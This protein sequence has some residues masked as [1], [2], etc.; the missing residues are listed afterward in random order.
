MIFYRLRRFLIS[1]PLLFFRDG[2]E[3]T[4]EEKNYD[5]LI[6]KVRNNEGFLMRNFHRPIPPAVALC[7]RQL[8]RAVVFLLW[9]HYIIQKQGGCRERRKESECCEIFAGDDVEGNL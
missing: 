6:R 3:A 4:S 9:V 8:A 2:D 5:D 1:S 7:G